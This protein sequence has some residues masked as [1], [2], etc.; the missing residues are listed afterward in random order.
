M[1]NAVVPI[2]KKFSPWIAEEELISALIQNRQKLT[3]FIDEIDAE[4]FNSSDCKNV[5]KMTKM[6]FEKYQSPPKKGVL[7]SSA[8]KLLANSSK[9][10]SNSVIQT[11]ERV[12]DRESLSDSELQYY[13][14]EL[15][16]FIKTGK[17]RDVIFEGINKI[18][19][20]NA[21]EEI[22]DKLKNA[23]LWRID[24]NLGI[25]ITDVKE[26]YAKQNEMLQSFVASPWPALNKAIGGGFFNKTLSCFVAGTSV[27][28][29]IALDQLG[30]Y[31]WSELQK[32]TLIISLELSEEIKS[33]RI[34]SMFLERFLGELPSRQKEVEQAYS[35]IES[36][37]KRLIIKEFPTSSVSVRKVA[38]F[39]SKLQ[40][41]SGFEPEIIIVDYGD[42]LLPNSGKRE[43]L[44][45]DGGAV[46]EAL[47]GLSY[48]FNC[49]VVTATQFNRCI[50]IESKVVLENGDT[51][52]IKDLQ[53]NDKILGSNGFVNVEKIYPI[54]KKKGF[55]I[56]TKSGKEIICS[57]EHKFPTKDGEK[58][59]NSGLSIGDF[60]IIRN[61]KYD[62]IVS[63]EEIDMVD[64]IDIQ[65]SGNNL[66]FANDILTHNSSGEKTPSEVNE[67]D[68]S[69]SHKKIMTL[70]TCIAIV[71]TPGMRAQG[72]AAFKTLK[73]R[74]GI[75]DYVL[76][77]NVSY[78]YFKFT[79]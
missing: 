27:G 28:K 64:M 53:I 72:Q 9:G 69:E 46:F 3:T 77:L 66:F 29:S 5:F 76:P 52:E 60:L 44:Y 25:D 10:I 24:E 45:A 41:Y 61:I 8:Q 65:V 47:R 36:N 34:D 68:I 33:M 50:F 6:Y 14:D 78:E 11:I 63:I 37:G 43:S 17:I 38:N 35:K 31:A 42:L 71:A 32:N 54:E 40:T 21:F 30:F 18:D 7:L 62:E 13:H 23:V 57:S 55:K 67:Y 51:I 26:R 56:K 39:I 16:K 73:A 4:F 22:Q 1:S 59:L 74:M 58:T 19:D 2:N 20:P 79:E 75:K 49:P 12:F 48:E 15:L 70:D